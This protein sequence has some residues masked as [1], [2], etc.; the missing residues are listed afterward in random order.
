[1]HVYMHVCIQTHTAR[2]LLLDLLACVLDLQAQWHQVIFYN[3]V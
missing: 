2:L 1:M 3:V